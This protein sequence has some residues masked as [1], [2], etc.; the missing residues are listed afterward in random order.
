MGIWGHITDRLTSALCKNL[1]TD[2]L[3]TLPIGQLPILNGKNGLE[4][5]P[6]QNGQLPLVPGQSGLPLLGQSGQGQQAM[7][8][9]PLGNGLGGLLGGQRNQQ[10]ATKRTPPRKNLL[11]IPYDF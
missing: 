7:S 8:N 10:P 1:I 11:G 3:G 2:L 9:I 4:L 6:G 5:L